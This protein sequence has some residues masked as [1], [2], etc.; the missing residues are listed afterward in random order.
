MTTTPAPPA[1]GSAGWPTWRQATE[2]ALYGPGG[3]FTHAGGPR[4]HFATATSAG[5]AL[6]QAL[7]G[8][9]RHV[10]AALGHPPRVDLV[11]AGAGGGDL[12]ARLVPLLPDDLARRVAPCVVERSPA[13][14]GWPDSWPWQPRMPARIRGLVLAVE[15]LD[16]VPLDVVVAT[17]DGPRLVLVDPRTG[18]E[19]AGPPPTGPDQA[20]LA[21]WWPLPPAGAGQRAEVGSPRDRLWAELVGAVSQGLLIAVDYGHQRDERVSGRWQEGSLA[22]YRAGRA[23]PVVPDGTADVTAHVA[24]DAVAAAGVAAGAG[25]TWLGRQRAALRAVAAGGVPGV[26]GD[27]GLGDLAARAGWAQLCDPV[28]LGAFYWLAQGVGMSLPGALS[29]AEHAGAAPITT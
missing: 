12:M 11:E 5:P 3:V 22:A 19:R 10:D 24:I 21:R 16:A 18:A 1:G 14:P 7:V 8:V 20:W 13:P 6:A 4:A 17:P 28:G 25:V 15:L 2:R 29:G 23:V 9:V 27:G 26:V